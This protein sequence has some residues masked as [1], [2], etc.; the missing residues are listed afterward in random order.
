M[1]DSVPAILG[2][3]S[4]V[5]ALVK[6]KRRIT[7]WRDAVRIGR[8][9][10]QDCNTQ[11][12]GGGAIGSL[13]ADFKRF[14]GVNYSLLFNSGTSALHA[15]YH[16]VGVGPE[17]E[18]IVPGYTFP[19]SATPVAL[20]GGSVKFCDIDPDTLTLDPESLSDLI[21][22][23]TKA[24]CAVHVWGNPADMDAILEICKPRGVAVIEDASHS[25]GALYKGRKVGTFGAIGCFSLQGRKAVT[26]GELGV[27]VTESRDLWERML[28]VGFFGR[29]GGEIRNPNNSVD[30]FSLGA[31]YRPHLFAAVLASSSL[32]RLPDL[33]ASR[34]LRWQWL[35]EELSGLKCVSPTKT[36][37]ESA[38][39]G[40]LE[41][42]FRYFPE[43]AGGLPV[44]S[45]VQA[46][47]AE[48]APVYV[49][50]YTRLGNRRSV[51][52][53]SFLFAKGGD[54]PSIDTL[55]GCRSVRDG[56]FAMPALTH[57]SESEVRSIGRAIRKVA[58]W[59]EQGASLEVGEDRRG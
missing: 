24:V 7:S 3:R 19:A 20:C 5:R 16:A 4:T 33:N 48:G 28:A 10:L 49:D 32:Q 14:F 18:V 36:L 15:A 35:Q 12:G 50:R 41:Y 52:A 1:K 9:L 56:L 26:G 43:E 51:I 39:G 38:R 54:R 37:P 21:S 34:A 6:D 45:F 2:G 30:G 11:P 47:C 57:N 17:T 22:P 29:T 31:K 55:S 42:V 40:F 44:G 23:R 59:A 27:A 13:E 58:S 53:E 8:L 25:P 46:L